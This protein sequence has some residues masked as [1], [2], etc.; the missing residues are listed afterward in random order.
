[1]ADYRYERTDA[2]IQRAFIRALATTG[3]EKLT[4]SQLAQASLVDRSTFYAHYPSIYELAETVIERQVAVIDH[5]LWASRT[6]NAATRYQLFS[7][8]LVTHL[9]ANAATISQ[10]RLIPLGT[11]SYDAQCRQSFTRY[12]QQAAGVAPDSFTSYLFVNMAMSDLDFVL[13]HR[14]APERA[15]LQVG[16][17]KIEQVLRQLAQD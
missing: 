3:F 1:M 2:D 15:E 4:V 11:A 13:A 12:Y 5:A 14:R 10:I 9:V 16:M 17:Q 8:D 7:S 6:A